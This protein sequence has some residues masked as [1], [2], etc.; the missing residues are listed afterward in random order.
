M[1]ENTST[2]TK[3]DFQI[4]DD[5]Y[6]N[7]TKNGCEVKII[8]YK[9]AKKLQPGIVKKEKYLWSPKTAVFSPN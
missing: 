3:K 4:I 9:E 8:N 7:A 2:F 5:I 6:N 1:R